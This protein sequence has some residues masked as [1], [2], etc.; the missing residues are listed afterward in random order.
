LALLPLAPKSEVLMSHSSAS[1]PWKDLGQREIFD[2]PWM[3]VVE[4]RVLRPD[5]TPGTYGVVRSKKLAVGVVPFTPFGEI[6]L[7]GQFRFPLGRYSWEIPE[8]GADGGESP[9]ETARRELKEETGYSAG[10]LER[11]LELDLSNCISDERAMG[12]LA[13]DLVPGTAAP[14]ATEELSMRKLPF[15]SV[16]RMVLNGEITDAISVAAILKVAALAGNR[17]LPPAIMGWVT[18]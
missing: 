11:F 7:V 8:G 10:R 9:D 3:R 5:G 13:W 15:S 6:V 16:L 4:H 17:A 1:N 2:N 12:F 14:D 18:G